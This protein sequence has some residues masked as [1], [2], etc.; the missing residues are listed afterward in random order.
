M[1]AQTKKAGTTYNIKFAVEEDGKKTWTRIGR[2]F[3]RAD[4]T[5][6]AAFIGDGE[7][8]KAYALFPAA[9]KKDD[10]AKPQPST[11]PPTQKDSKPGCVGALNPRS[12][13]GAFR[14][15]RQASGGAGACKGH[16]TIYCA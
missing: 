11:A 5:G 6:G 10:G 14:R 13:P 4:G 12:P 1:D 15:P 16:R 3:I 9:P 8:E 2:L 7:N